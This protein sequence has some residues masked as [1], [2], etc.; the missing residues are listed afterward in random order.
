[1]PHCP[2]CDKQLP[3]PPIQWQWS[4]P[5]QCSHCG[6]VYAAST[7]GSLFGI[8][9]DLD[10]LSPLVGFDIARRWCFYAGRTNFYVYALCY[11][12]GLPFYVGS[13]QNERVLS[14]VAEARS[15]RVAKTEKHNTIDW[16]IL[17]GEPVWYHFLALVQTK[18]EALAIENA[19]IEAWGRRCDGGILTN[20]AGPN[21]HEIEQVPVRPPNWPYDEPEIKYH[22]EKVGKWDRS[23]RVFHHSDH[24]VPPPIGYGIVSGAVSKC[25]ACGELGQ[26]TAE[27]KYKKLLCGNCGHYFVPFDSKTNDDGSERVYF[28]KALP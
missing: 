1:M 22:T 15:E 24:V 25:N 19:F 21:Y 13:G 27:M 3:E 7:D 18:Q 17:H 6:C 10:P 14:H 12:S 23:I 26:H 2:H 28:T 5:W 20:L 9:D 4:A 16:L 11:S 8:P